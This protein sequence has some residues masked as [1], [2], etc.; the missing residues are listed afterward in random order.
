MRRFC[1]ENCN[2]CGILMSH[3]NR[4]VSLILNILY[5]KFGEDVYKIVQNACPNLTCCADCH[6]DDFTHFEGCE[7]DLE[8]I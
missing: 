8:A 5:N 2:Q 6:V 1:D 7:I 4:Q 3:N